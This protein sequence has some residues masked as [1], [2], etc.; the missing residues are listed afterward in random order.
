VE[1]GTCGSSETQP[2]A[3]RDRSA[4][5]R[6]SNQRGDGVQN[7]VSLE[8]ANSPSTVAIARLI[9]RTQQTSRLSRKPIRYHPR[10][11]SG[12]PRSRV[13]RELKAHPARAG[14]TRRPAARTGPRRCT[15]TSSTTTLE[16]CDTKRNG[17]ETSDRVAYLYQMLEHR[18]APPF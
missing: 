17:S 11:T 7:Q 16:R 3:T 6:I 14:D 1:V 4:N 5:D 10:L 13:K 18:C 8:G 15:S 12:R 2:W 9:T